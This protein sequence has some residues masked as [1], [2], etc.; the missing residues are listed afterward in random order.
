MPDPAATKAVQAGGQRD[1][2]ALPVTSRRRLQAPP[3]DYP[4]P[5]RVSWHITS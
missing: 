1:V 5:A 2:D 4:L 3:R